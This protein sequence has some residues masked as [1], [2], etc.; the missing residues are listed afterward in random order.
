MRKYYYF[1]LLLSMVFSGLPGVALGEATYSAVTNVV[2]NSVSLTIS[3]GST[4]DEITVDGGTLS[5]VLS[6]GHNFVIN[7]AERWDFNVSGETNTTVTKSLQSD[8]SSLQ[9]KLGAGQASETITVTVASTE[10]AGN[11]SS[12][13]NTS[14]GGGGGG[15]GSRSS[16]RSTTSDTDDTDDTETT[17]ETDG[18][19]GSSISAWQQLLQQYLSEA[20]KVTAGK[21][22][23]LGDTGASEDTQAESAVEA[24]YI[25]PLVA[26]TGIVSGDN[27]A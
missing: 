2:L 19:A 3:A 10:L 1:I 18:A 27:K 24:K 15:G 16:S 6:A 5:V 7:S 21:N 22:E 11:S 23:V 20:G 13:G 9:L 12:G 4:V 14:G 8:S 25:A 26:T 17:G